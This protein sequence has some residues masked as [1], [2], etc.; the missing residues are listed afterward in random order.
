MF[1]FLVLNMLADSSPPSLAASFVCAVTTHQKGGLIARKGNL[2]LYSAYRAIFPSVRSSDRDAY[3]NPDMTHCYMIVWS[4]AC[5]DGT[6]RHPKKGKIAHCE[7]N[8][9]VQRIC[10]LERVRSRVHEIARHD[11]TDHAASSMLLDT[12]SSYTR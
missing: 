12:A 4:Q 1:F 9:A 7:F 8:K 10:G 11:H 6:R 5:H 2:S 3:I